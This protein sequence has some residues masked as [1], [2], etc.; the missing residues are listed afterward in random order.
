MP[1][2]YPSYRSGLWTPN[3]YYIHLGGVEWTLSCHG[4]KQHSIDLHDVS[5]DRG[6]GAGAGKAGP[7]NSKLHSAVGWSLVITD[8]SAKYSL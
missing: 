7:P 3:A 4:L 1:R 8:V 5:L 2:S 6:L